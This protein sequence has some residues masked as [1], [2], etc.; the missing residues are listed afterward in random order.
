MA[1]VKVLLEVTVED[2]PDR[3]DVGVF[4]PDTVGAELATYAD[5]HLGDLTR[6][7]FDEPWRVVNVKLAQ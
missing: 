1:R 2:T 6:K 7:E 3:E 4:D 5:D